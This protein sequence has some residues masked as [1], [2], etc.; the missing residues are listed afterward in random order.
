MVYVP[1]GVPAGTATTPVAG[2]SAGTG[3]PPIDV[4]GV[5]TASVALPVAPT[6]AGEPLTVSLLRALPAVGLPVAP[7]M[8]V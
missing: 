2:F 8:P 6:V 7:L 4:A 1:A 3:P 5:L